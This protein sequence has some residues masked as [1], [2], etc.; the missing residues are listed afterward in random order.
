MILKF[1]FR[2]RR[3]YTNKPQSGAMRGHG[4]VNSRFAVETLLD[5]LA[6]KANI[7]PCQLRLDNLISENSITVGQ[8]RITSKRK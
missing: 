8:Y 4:A 2:T 3:V 7:D 1:G 6:Q 5:E